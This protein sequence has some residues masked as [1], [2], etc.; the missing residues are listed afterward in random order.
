M[1]FF[2]TH[3]LFS[4]AVSF[5][6]PTV[7]RAAEDLVESQDPSFQ[8]DT[9]ETQ[10][11]E[12][13]YE[14]KDPF[15]SLLRLTPWR[16]PDYEPHPEFRIDDSQK[17]AVQFWRY[18]YSELPGDKGVIHDAEDLRIIYMTIDFSDIN[19]RSDIHRFRKEHL[20]IQRIKQR[21]YEVAQAL[22]QIL[23]KKVNSE[24]AHEISRKYSDWIKKRSIN[25][26]VKNIRFQLGQK[27]KIVKAIFYSGLYLRDFEKIFSSEGLPLELVRLPFVESSYNPLAQSRVGASGLWQ[28]MPFVPTAKERRFLSVDLRNFPPQATR[29]AAR[30]LRNNY[31]QLKSWPLAVTAYN[32]G[33]G[34]I[35]RL[36]KICR[37]RK[38]SD[39]SDRKLC[40]GK[41]LGFASRNFWPSFM[42][43]LEIEK[44]ATFFLGPVYLADP[45]KSSVVYLE[46]KLYVSDAMSRFQG[47]AA[48]FDLLNPHLTWRARRGWIPL[49]KGVPLVLLQ[50]K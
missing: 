30:L 38:L 45:P 15:S 1:K 49:E 28:I 32:H 47:P 22:R 2:M 9:D 18:V 11:S 48:L 16:Q 26:L 10:D 41:R 36:T 20:R 6:Y 7:V 33:A 3:L 4:F 21:K 46:K 44:Q 12:T 34:G 8:E 27:D 14:T 13:Y 40:R 17:E 5:G 31:N 35:E 25:D 42:A 19:R 50:G 29:M 43:I 39:L 23:T 24:L 37:S